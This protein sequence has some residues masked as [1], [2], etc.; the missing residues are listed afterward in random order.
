[1]SPHSVDLLEIASALDSGSA[2]FTICRLADGVALTG[3]AFDGVAAYC[4]LAGS[5]QLELPGSMGP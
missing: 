3:P 4:V 1:M 2:A 5:M